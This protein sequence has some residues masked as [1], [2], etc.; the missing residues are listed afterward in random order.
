MVEAAIVFPLL[1]LLVLGAFDYG[2]LFR[3]DLTMANMTR[4]GA[5]TASALGQSTTADYS[6]LSAISSASSA[7]QS[8]RG[9]VQQI[10]IFDA[11]CGNGY[12][13]ACDSTNDPSSAVP[14]ACTS[15]AVT[16]ECNVYTAAD[17]QALSS[18]NF[19]CGATQKDRFWC[20]STRVTSESGNGG[21]GPDYLGV[22]LVVNHQWVTG[23]FGPSRVLHDTVVFR[24]EP[25][26]L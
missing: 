22:Y 8:G 4:Q 1:F 23:M 15:G 7:L 26:S 21:K 9:S 10:V 2:L 3:D 13:V 24:L 12:T 14:T 25:T 11:T 18:S 5:R 16:N 17:L 19:G 6:I 20:P